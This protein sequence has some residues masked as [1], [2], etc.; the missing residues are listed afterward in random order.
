M[1]AGV[2]AYALGNAPFQ[3]YGEALKWFGLGALLSAVAL[4][5]ANMGGM[6][7]RGEG[8]SLNDAPPQ[9]VRIAI[10]VAGCGVLAAGVLV[11]GLISTV[12]LLGS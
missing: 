12:S 3:A 2:V 6:D 8:Y 7:T 5:L 11:K 9:V 4:A 10:G 1:M